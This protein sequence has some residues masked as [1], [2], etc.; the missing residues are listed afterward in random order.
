MNSEHHNFSDDSEPMELQFDDNEK[1]SSAQASYNIVS[2]TVTGVNVRFSDNLFQ[3]IFIVVS[4]FI[5]SGVGILIGAGPGALLG[6]FAGLVLGVL[7]SG[8]LLMIYR[9]IRHIQG[10]HK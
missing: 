7:A 4:I 9:A 10:K 2:D 3:A 6:A 8:F 5:C 1:V